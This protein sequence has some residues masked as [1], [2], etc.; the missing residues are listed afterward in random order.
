MKITG[1]YKN[2]ISKVPQKAVNILKERKTQNPE[3]EL[4]TVEI[5]NNKYLLIY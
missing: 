4:F 5:Y 2:I 3:K 1:Y